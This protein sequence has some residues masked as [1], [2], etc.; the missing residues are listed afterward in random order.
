MTDEIRTPPLHTRQDDVTAY[1]EQ[2]YQIID[3]QT[4]TTTTFPKTSKSTNIQ[5]IESGVDK[6]LS[7]LD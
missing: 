4:E 5:D 7:K 1:T 6:L 3:E 2:I